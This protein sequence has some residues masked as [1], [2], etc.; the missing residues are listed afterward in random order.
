MKNANMGSITS[1]KRLILSVH[2][3][4]DCNHNHNDEAAADITTIN[5]LSHIPSIMTNDT[6]ICIG[7][8]D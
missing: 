7:N 8:W 1:D 5:A 3:S 2:D 6:W 4:H